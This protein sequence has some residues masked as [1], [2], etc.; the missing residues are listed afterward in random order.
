MAIFL[1]YLV[2]IDIEKS[3]QQIK[4]F[5]EQKPFQ[6]AIIF[7]L[8]FLV[9]KFT[10]IPM[11]SVAIFAGYLFGSFWGSIV[12]II[13]ITL[14]STLIFLLARFLGKNFTI[15]FL[16]EKYSRLKRYNQKLKTKGFIT[17]LFFR[18]VPIFPLMV[19]NLGLGI[20]RV[21]LTDYTLATI[22]GVAPGVIILTHA[23]KYLL[24]WKNPK[25]YIFLGLYLILLIGTFLIR[26][27]FL[28]N[29][30]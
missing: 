27:I 9:L 25:L 10:F 12:A 1:G 14:S 19:I 24:D 22:L 6:G 15:K 29:K 7:I 30:K 11:I 21:K 3:L 18:V 4:S 13:A 20:S 17:V 28:K 16:E 2:D 26:N 5:S 8:F 23:G